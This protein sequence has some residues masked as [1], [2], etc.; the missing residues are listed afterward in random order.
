MKIQFSEYH[1][2]SVCCSYEDPTWSNKDFFL[3]KIEI[4]RRLP[5][6][7]EDHI[8]LETTFM[9]N[10]LYFERQLPELMKYLKFSEEV[11]R[12]GEKIINSWNM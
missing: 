4:L 7:S 5:S 11:I 10:S 2:L 8:S 1:G 3:K 9:Q 12:N 6:Y